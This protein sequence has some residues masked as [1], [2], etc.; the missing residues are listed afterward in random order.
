MTSRVRPNRRADS[1]R[2]FLAT[3]GGLALNFMIVPRHVL[4]G[5]GYIA[6]SERVNVAGIGAGGMGGGDIATVAAWAPTSSPC[7]TS[8]TSAPPVL[9][10]R[11]QGTAVQRLPRDARQGREADRRGHRRHAR[12]HSRRRVDGGDPRGQARLLSEAADS[13]AA[14]MPR[15]DQG[16][17]RRPASPPRWAIRDTPPK[18]PRLTN[19][20]IQAGV[21]GEVREVHVW[22]DRAGRLW[23]QG[24]GRPTE[25]PPVPSHPGLEPL[26]GADPRAALSPGVCSGELARLVGFRHRRDWATWAATSS[27][28]PSGRLRL[29]PPSARR[30]PHDHRRIVLDGDKPNSETYPIAA[31][32]YYEFPARGELPA[33]RMTW[34]DGGLM[35]PAPAEMPPDE[36]L[37]DNGV[38]YVGSKGKMYPRFSRRHAAAL[39]RTALHEEAAKVPKTMRTIARALRRMG[40]RL[41]GRSEA[42]LELRL[43]RPADRDRLAGRAGP[44]GTGP[45]AGMGQ[46]EPEDQERPGAQSPGARR[47]S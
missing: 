40:G 47:V 41:Q 4:G 3:T 9:S 8:T 26:A 37:P 44:Q 34:Y 1:R 17:S 22:S 28:T 32:I 46:R 33:V 39:C 12:P 35:P 24:I 18:A 42:G 29:G 19:E 21:I 13:H 6:P 7:A 20:W 43:F 27:I 10:T 16:R 11:S 5:T 23:K 36:R 31:I 25:T 15:A 30:G 45:T 14:R 2:T 38:L